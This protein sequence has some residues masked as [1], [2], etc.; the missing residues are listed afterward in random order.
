MISIKVNDKIK[1]VEE[2]ELIMEKTK[3][4][5]WGVIL[6]I[7]GIVWGLNAL[8]ITNIDIFFEGWW[9]FIIIIPSF[10]GLLTEKNKSDNALGLFLGI[11]L[12]LG[13]RGIIKIDLIWK[14]FVPIALIVIGVSCIF[15]NKDRD[16]NKVDKNGKTECLAM[17]SSQKIK[18]VDDSIKKIE[19]TALMGSVTCDLTELKIN[20]DIKIEA[21]SIFGSVNLIMPDNVE[22]KIK[23]FS[24]FGGV[25]EKQNNNK[26][27]NS[28]VI[29]LDST[30][31]FG[32]INIK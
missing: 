2:M 19:V 28:K 4:I 7:I 16:N 31:I 8:E 24:L 15:K 6:I 5:L 12:F 25:T 23:S 10:I 1:M 14:L 22:I 32:G 13:A 20:E 18:P 26:S 9:A 17:F 11:L 29:Y 27:K 21:A 3:N 30:S